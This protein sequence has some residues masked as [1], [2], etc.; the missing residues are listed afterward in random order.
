M[1][2]LTFRYST[3]VSLP[4]IASRFSLVCLIRV[5]F[6]EKTFSFYFL[7][8]ID[9]C[10]ALGYGFFLNLLGPCHRVKAS[11]CLL[12]LHES[13]SIPTMYVV[14]IW[15]SGKVLLVLSDQDVTLFS[16]RKLYR[17]QTSP[18]CTCPF[19]LLTAPFF[20]LQIAF[21]RSWSGKVYRRSASMWV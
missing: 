20:Q 12:C 5:I 4:C 8:T 21:V 1:H 3:T 16:V 19:L 15:W 6:L 7:C 13:F 2:D 18:M 9:R 10:V 14:L 11:S 17:A